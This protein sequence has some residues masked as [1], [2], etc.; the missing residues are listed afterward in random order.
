[1][2]TCTKGGT[3]MTDF[4]AVASIS[5]QMVKCTSVTMWMEFEKDDGESRRNLE[6]PLTIAGP[7]CSVKI[8]C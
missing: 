6:N 3:R 1:M 7:H 2:V 5:G 8:C 4:T